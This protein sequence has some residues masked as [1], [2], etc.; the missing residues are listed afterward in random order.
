MILEEILHVSVPYI[1]AVLEIV[2]VLIIALAGIQGIIM[3][4]KDGFNFANKEIPV[5]L[6]TA[7]SL[8]L[9]FL[10]AA[11]VLLTIMVESTHDLIHI[12]GIAGLR[13]GIHFVLHWELSHAE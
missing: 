8:A 12:I 1:A 5:K 2:G 9:D 13:I 3:F 4:I 10:L 6:A 11:E 7:M